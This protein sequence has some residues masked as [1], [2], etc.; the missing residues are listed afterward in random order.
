MDE[1]TTLLN[2]DQETGGDGGAAE[3]APPSLGWRTELPA[4][5]RDHAAFKDY[6][7]KTDLWQGHVEAVTKVQELQAKLKN[8]IPKL[9]ENPTED[10][11]KAFRKA[12]GVPESPDK[13][14][15]PAGDEPGSLIG[16]F[17]PIAYELGLTND[18][19]KQLT[20]RWEELAASIRALENKR[21]E[22]EMRA[23]VDALKKEWGDDLEGNLMIVKTSFDMFKDDAL[24]DLLETDVQ[25]GDKV[26]KLG[27]HP[28]VIKFM[29]EIGKRL[30]P[31]NIV[32]GLPPTESV[33]P[34]TGIIKY[35]WSKTGGST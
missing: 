27:N 22:D 10:D 1:D 30:T 12:L 15:L 2:A 16:W 34:K 4:A 33:D 20:A 32:G 8:A 25:L 19:A 5:L 17:K 31:D 18:Q 14:D 7:T 6:A 21:Y 29:F 13:Y 23:A 35:D 9:G 11:L 3:T 26:I 28:S 24:V